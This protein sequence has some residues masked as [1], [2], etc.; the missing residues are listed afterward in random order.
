[1]PRNCVQIHQQFATINCA[2]RIFQSVASL[3][4]ALSQTHLQQAVGLLVADVRHETL[5]KGVI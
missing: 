5:S 2:I 3:L 1:M 4:S